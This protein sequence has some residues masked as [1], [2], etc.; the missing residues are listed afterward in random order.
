MTITQSLISFIFT[1]TLLVLTPGLD[2][3]LVLRT[4]TVDGANRAFR[5]ALGILTGCC[6]W[7]LAAAL[8]LSAM[9]AASHIAFEILK[10]GGALYLAWVG[11]QLLL[12]PRAHFVAESQ[13]R[14]FIA[15]PFAKGA[16]QN[17]LNPKIGVFYISFLPQFI[18]H[19]VEAGP[20]IL[21]LAALHV[22]I[23]LVWFVALILMTHSLAPFMRN[24]SFVRIMD[25]VTGIV[26]V[27]FGLK[28]AFSRN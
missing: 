10:W 13:P 25:R 17:L 1:I 4:A 7:G 21:M 26:F 12:H 2:M 9:L 19:G 20:Y 16:M 28:L 3:A 27:G 6:V 18:P 22:A 11:S 15:D 23:C 14:T 24:P 5:A 8:G